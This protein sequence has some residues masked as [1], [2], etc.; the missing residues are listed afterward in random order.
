MT[1]RENR[2]MRKRWKQNVA[3]FR[4]RQ[5]AQKAESLRFMREN[6]P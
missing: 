6:H 5:A 3:A 1:P 2:I 4:R